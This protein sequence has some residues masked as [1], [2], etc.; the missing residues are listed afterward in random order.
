MVEMAI[1]NIYDIQRAVTPKV[2]KPELILVLVFFT[3]SH[4]ALHL[5]EIS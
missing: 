3:L 1:F 5:C 4:G 2:G